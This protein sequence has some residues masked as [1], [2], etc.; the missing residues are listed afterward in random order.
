ML[1]AYIIE[2]IKRQEEARRDAE[3]RSRRRLRIDR[4]RPDEERRE[5]PTGPEDGV[6]ED[7]PEGPVRIDIDQPTIRIGS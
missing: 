7:A 1:D 5:T 3:R 4:G 2:D 6:D